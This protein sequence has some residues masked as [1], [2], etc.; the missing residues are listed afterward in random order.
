VGEIEKA[1]W[2]QR[3]K[4]CQRN[5]LGDRMVGQQSVAPILGHQPDTA[6]D[7][8]R[9]IAYADGDAADQ[10]LARHRAGPGP[11][12]GDQR[13]GCQPDRHAEFVFTPE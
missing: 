10:D 6:A 2:C 3:D 13:A 12:D 11:E 4:A 7:G 5:V 9:R 8:V 1:V